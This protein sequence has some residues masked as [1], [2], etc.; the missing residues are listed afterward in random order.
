MIRKILYKAFSALGAKEVRAYERASLDC[1]Q[2]QLIRLKEIIEPNIQSNYGK[3]HSFE[4]IKN[5][6]DFQ[7]AVPINTYDQLSPYIDRMTRGERNVLTAEDPFMFAITSGTSGA[8]KFIPIN[9]AYMAEFRRASTV[10]GY[11]MLKNYPQLPRGLTLSIFSPAEEG[12]TEGGIPYGAISGRLYLDEPK[13]IKK[14]V[15]PL[16]YELFLIKDYEA[17]YYSILRC[18]LMLPI[19]CIYTLNPSTIALLGKRLKTFGSALVRDIAK[20]TLNPPGEITPDTRIAL[21]SFLKAN[22]KRAL[23]LQTLLDK[24]Q[25]RADT[26][27]PELTLISCWTKAA[28]AFYLQDFPEL[29]GSTPIC[30]ITYGASEG[31]GTVCL[32]PDKQGLSINSHF[33]EFVEESEIDK[34][35]PHALLGHELT[36]GNNYY[37]LFTT[38]AG[39]YRYNINDIVKV[40]GFHNTVPLLEFMHKGGNISSFTGEKLTESQVTAAVKA[41]SHKLGFTVNFFTVVPEFRPEPHYNLLMEGAPDTSAAFLEKA[42]KV[43]DE[44]LA[45]SNTEYGAK[46]ESKRL[47]APNVLPL[48]P[49][50]YEH[51]RK[52]LVGKG[53]PDAQIKISHLNPKPDIKELLE[54][55]IVRIECRAGS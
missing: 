18:A 11:S 28:A 19:S 38:S 4:K 40:V 27:W 23:Q 45:E 42:A 53:V 5:A 26:A 34:E 3:Q 22:P 51:M 54:P 33:F 50:S 55:R 6:R 2:A 21:A 30:D 49:G 29:F 37:I 12:R 10:S 48:S 16:P 32:A 31:R 7:Q 52:Y 39:L 17:R 44:C 13:F 41:M 25:L 36:V 8:R 15:S 14:F 20:G 9:S 47:A 35:N 46:R 24:N 1:Q 43:L